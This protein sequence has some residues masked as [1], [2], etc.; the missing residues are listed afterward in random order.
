MQQRP[1][2]LAA[3]Y[4]SSRTFLWDYTMLNSSPYQT[5]TCRE[6]VLNDRRPPLNRMGT[7]S[8]CIFPL[9]LHGLAW[10]S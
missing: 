1:W 3:A 4:V 6:N 8:L 7:G 2:Y 5:V 10:K 9:V